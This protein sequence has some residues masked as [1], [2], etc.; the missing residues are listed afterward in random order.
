MS[1]RTVA[2]SHVEQRRT[3][4]CPCGWSTKSGIRDTNAA[5]KL[6]KKFCEK[7]RA[8]NPAAAEANSFSGVR[9]SRHG[10]PVHHPD[11]DATK[12]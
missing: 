7:A 11:S 1:K 5:M 8:F 2:I 10:N 3:T 4:I 12:P 9:R 6:H